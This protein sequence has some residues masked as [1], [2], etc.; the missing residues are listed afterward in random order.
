M[1]GEIIPR[2]DLTSDQFNEL[3]PIISQPLDLSSLERF[4]LSSPEYFV[5]G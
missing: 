5:N 4:V 1:H 3:P 2:Q